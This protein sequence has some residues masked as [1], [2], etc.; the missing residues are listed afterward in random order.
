MGFMLFSYSAPQQ[1]RLPSAAI[2]H[3]GQHLAG[4]LLTF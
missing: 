4:W 1:L 2:G 3:G